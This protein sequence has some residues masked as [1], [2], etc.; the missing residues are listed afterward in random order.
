MMRLRWTRTILCA[1]GFIWVMVQWHAHERRATADQFHVAELI[2][3]MCNDR[4]EQSG[5]DA[6]EI[7]LRS[8]GLGSGVRVSGSVDVSG[9]VD[10]Q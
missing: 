2:A 3:R 4:S 1:L 5:R 7:G 6:C 10:V 8:T 9:N